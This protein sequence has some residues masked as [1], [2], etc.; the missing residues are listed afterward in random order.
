MNLRGLITA[1]VLL[2]LFL[3][4]SSSI[5]DQVDR[6]IELLKKGDNEKRIFASDALSKIGNERAIPPLIEAL[7][8]KNNYLRSYFIQAIASFGEKG[9]PMLINACSSP[10]PMIRG[11]AANTLGKI[12]N[13]RAI[14]TLISL[15]SDKEIS[16]QKNAVIALNNFHDEKI[17]NALINTLRVE[18][19]AENRS[20]L[21]K[22]L[23][24]YKHKSALQVL[25]AMTKDSDP[26]VRKDAVH[27]LINSGFTA[28]V[29]LPLIESLVDQDE[30]VQSISSEGLVASGKKGAFN[31]IIEG[32][33]HKNPVVRTHISSILGDIENREAVPV[34]IRR[35]K[36]DEQDAVKLASII[37]LGKLK[38]SRATEPLI[39]MLESFND[40][41][42]IAAVESLGKIG[43]KRAIEPLIAALI[44]YNEYVQSGAIVALGDMGDERAVTALKQIVRN[45]KKERIRKL[46]EE[47]YKRIQK[48]SV[49]E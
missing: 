40:S 22:S 48:T 21:V 18:T 37:S 19:A 23:G 30:E 9:V 44:D 3:M 43:D 38:D 34:L 7:E 16:V 8:T 11:N 20:F 5:A 27:A 35:L 31:Q 1:V 42:R 14:D 36:E 2:S 41:I 47:T 6:L 13:Q 49:S 10:N 33:N 12:G 26:F 17:M 25:I 45:D 46:A 29:V 15:L 28:E 4:P 24:E 32:M 39:A